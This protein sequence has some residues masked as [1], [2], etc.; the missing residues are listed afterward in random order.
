MGLWQKKAITF[1]LK[2]GPYTSQ[3]RWEEEGGFSPFTMATEIAALL[4]GAEL[5]EIS[6]EKDFAIYCRETADSWN[7][8]IE[9]RTYVT[10]TPPG[11]KT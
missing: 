7:D 1:L 8:T 5:A 3:D 11:P 6:N 9:Y 10:G 2:N 4:A